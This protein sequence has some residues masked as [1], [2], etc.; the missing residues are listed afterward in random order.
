MPTEGNGAIGALDY[1][2]EERAVFAKKS[3][4]WVCSICGCKNAEALPDETVV[5]HTTLQAEPEITFGVKGQQGLTEDLNEGGEAAA[6]ENA[7]SGTD[8]ELA[9]AKVSDMEKESEVRNGARNVDNEDLKVVEGVANMSLNVEHPKTTDSAPTSD[10]SDNSNAAIIPSQPST[11]T[12][13]SGLRQR[14]NSGFPESSE[15]SSSSSPDTAPPTSSSSSSSASAAATA[16]SP[17]APTP[18]VPTSLASASQTPAAPQQRTD[19]EERMRQID[20]AILVLV[21]FTL[22]LVVRRAGMIMAE[23]HDQ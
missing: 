20:T 9:K 11:E 19:N 4:E 6:G 14:L 1:T 5:G 7:S 12:S 21:T 8:A 13:T 2:E 15:S 3:R 22:Y 10:S 18:T 17:L 23:L 16:S